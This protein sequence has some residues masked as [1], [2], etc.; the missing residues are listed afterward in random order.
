MFGREVVTAMV[1]GSF[2]L[3]IWGLMWYADKVSLKRLKIRAPQNRLQL[4]AYA[5]E[6]DELR[7]R[8]LLI[9]ATALAVGM[10]YLERQ[11]SLDVHQCARRNIDLPE[12]EDITPKL[13][14]LLEESDEGESVESQDAFLEDPNIATGT[15]EI[16]A[17]TIISHGVPSK[18]K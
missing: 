13:L 16:S 12:Y 2:V 7:E 8:G 10:E 17:G 6:W 15:F 14:R 9:R 1:L 5:K 11:A 3:L 4:I 18:E